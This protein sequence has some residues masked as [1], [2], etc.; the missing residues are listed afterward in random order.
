[1]TR[2]ARSWDWFPGELELLAW[3]G[4]EV[5]AWRP[6]CRPDLVRTVDEFVPWTTFARLVERY[7]G[8]HRVRM[9]SS[10]SAVRGPVLEPPCILHF[11]QATS[12]VE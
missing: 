5:S 10:P 11:P 8:D 4:C 9:R 12:P 1:M 7:C 6:I 2:N 3:R